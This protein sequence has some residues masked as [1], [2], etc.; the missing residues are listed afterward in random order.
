MIINLQRYK[1]NKYLCTSM[2]SFRYLLSIVLYFCCFQSMWS[3]QKY[4]IVSPSEFRE[5]LQPFVEWKRQTG[6]LVKECYIDTNSPETIHQILQS[7]YDHATLLDPAPSYVLLV[8][9]VDRLGT[10]AGRHQ[11][12][13]SF[14]EIATDL[15][16]VE[17]T[18]D[19]RPDAMLGRWSVTDVSQLADVVAKTLRYERY[20]LCSHDYLRQSLVVAGR[21]TSTVGVPVPTLTNGQVNYVSRALREACDEMDTSCFY[22]PDS[23]YQLDTIVSLLRTGRGLIYY[24]S[25]CITDGWLHPS[26]DKDIIDTLSESFPA[27]YVNNCCLSSRFSED[28]FG[29]HLLRKAQG[30]AVGV[31]GA[32][33]ET[34][35]N[36]DY[37]WSLGAKYPFSR[38]PDYDANLLGMFDRWLHRYDEPELMHAATLGQ[39][40]FAGNGAVAQFESPYEDYYW[41]IYN[42]LGDPSL[43]PYVGEPEELLLSC[44]SVVLRGDASLSVSTLAGALVAVTQGD[45][46]LGVAVADSLG[47]SE[48]LFAHPAMADSLC[49]TATLQNHIPSVAYLPVRRARSARLTVTDYSIVV[50]DFVVLRLDVTNVGEETAFLHQISVEDTIVQCDTLTP[51]ASQSFLLRFPFVPDTIPLFRTMV[52]MIDA[53]GCYASMQIS[54]DAPVTYPTLLSVTVRDSA[55]N[56]VQSLSTNS[57]YNLRV[58]LSSYADSLKVVLTEFPSMRETDF[59]FAETLRQVTL[60]FRLSDDTRRVRVTITSFLGRWYREYDYWMLTGSAVET[61]ESGDFFSF[62]WDTTA[63]RPWIPTQ[64]QA[65]EGDFSA[66]SAVISS[67]QTSRLSIP[68]FVLEDDTV[69]FWTRVSSEEGH[70]RLYFYIDDQLQGFWSGI[71]MWTKR[72]FPIEQGCHRL[73]WRYEKDDTRNENQDCI[74]IDDIRFPLALW[75]T[76]DGVWDTSTVAIETP[77]SEEL[78]V[79]IYP[80]PASGQCHIALSDALKEASLTIYDMSGRRVAAYRVVPSTLS[81]Q[82]FRNGIYTLVFVNNNVIT[83]RKLMVRSHS[84]N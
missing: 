12:N 36:E 7:Y 53:E 29:E 16:Y 15:Y 39:M 14:E 11:P 18:G 1:K 30:G 64:S 37:Y 50:Q 34:L 76:L 63:L 74:W 61:F 52:R 69:S 78:C 41:E 66:R 71:S 23:E 24:T 38:V 42:I 70:D 9:D 59:T 83:T 79:N 65:H 77:K 72:S 60:P 68:L 54:S 28:C 45:E 56:A 26:L 25:H 84:K 31:I 19:S 46:L 44:D 27:V 49:V 10:F 51:D 32:S 2:R 58:D 3:Q 43:M 20:Q 81:L 5:T 17:F 75:D 22:N 67:R 55:E 80:N 57:N 62:P 73:S 21:E 13:N 33:N 35:W 4:V 47:H 8:G 82:S 40:L 48:V 6:F